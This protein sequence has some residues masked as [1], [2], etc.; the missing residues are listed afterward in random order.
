MLTELE[1][2]REQWGGAKSAIDNWLNERQQVVVL[3]N[4]VS[5][6]IAKSRNIQPE[7]ITI[8][9][10]CQ[11]LMDYVSAGHFEVYERIVSECEEHGEQSLHLAKRLYPKIARTTDSVLAFNDKYGDNQFEEEMR[12][13]DR[14]WSELGQQLVTRMELEDEM[15][16]T[17][18]TNH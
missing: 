1:K 4:E 5:K 9:N 15:I 2:A 12:E 8:Q 16:H 13:L 17:L 14:D 7:Q 11:I 10:F 18:H 3:Y 6:L